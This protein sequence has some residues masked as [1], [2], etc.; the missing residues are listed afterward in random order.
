MKRPR[1]LKPFCGVDGEGSTLSGRHEYMLL[2][3]GSHL[4]TTGVPL[5][6]GECLGFLAG[7]PA[8]YE[9]VGFFFDYDVTMICRDLPAEVVLSL[10]DRESR[11]REDGRGLHPVQWGMWEFDY[12]PRKEF[13]VRTRVRQDMPKRHWT[14][15]SDVGTFFQCSFVKAL[16][17]WGIGSVSV[18]AQIAAGKAERG[19]FGAM[20]PEI[21]RYNELEI[22]LLEDLMEEFRSVCIEVGIVPAKWQ[23]P[24]NVATAL[25]KMHGIPTHDE[26]RHVPD[27]VW[28]MAQAAYYGGRFETTGQ[29]WMK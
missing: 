20:T 6:P 22:E 25:F 7:L 19:N 13:R 29:G 17:T 27:D 15:V 5:T 18:L 23:G 14:V 21:V 26:L 28:R 4:L 1:P 10:L 24:G 2:R 8:G 12:L 3:A 16:T 9:Y 11:E